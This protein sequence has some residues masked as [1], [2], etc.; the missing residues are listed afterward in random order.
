[1]SEKQF[2]II[3]EHYVGYYQGT[4]F[5][6]SNGEEEWY[7][8]EKKEKAQELVD[9]LNSLSKENEQLRQFINNGKRLSVK[10]LMDNINENLVLK[11]KIRGLEKENDK[12]KKELDNFKP[13]MFQ[14][15]RKGTVILYSKE[16]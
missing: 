5:L 13:V 15:M 14:D 2:E 4:A 7:I 8:W 9:L 11:K 16:G 1:M 10:E 3:D 6:M 12:L